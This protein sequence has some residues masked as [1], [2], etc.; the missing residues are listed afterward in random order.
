MAGQVQAIIDPIWN[1]KYGRREGSIGSV[2]VD[3]RRW[4]VARALLVR[5][6]RS[7][8]EQGMTQCKLNV[9]SENLNGATS[10]YETCGFKVDK[11]DGVYR[12]PL[13]EKDL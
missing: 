3:R 2:S 7:Q 6:L 13:V 8:K 4:W 11:L 1:E 12:K 5:S 10:L 9:D